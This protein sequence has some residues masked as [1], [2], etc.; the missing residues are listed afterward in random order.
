MGSARAS[1]R[2]L[3]VPTLESAWTASR[4]LLFPAALGPKSTVN[5][6]YSMATF[7]NDLNPSIE[8]R[9]SIPAPTFRL[10]PHPQPYPLGLYAPSSPADPPGEALE[11]QGNLIAVHTSTT[12]KR[13]V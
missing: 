1:T 6:G 12:H 8:S 3:P 7:R 9:L 11:C 4:T 13:L 2:V 5:F 10:R